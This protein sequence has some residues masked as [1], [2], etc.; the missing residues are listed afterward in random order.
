MWEPARRDR[1]N[2]HAEFASAAA[3]I[4][5]PSPLPHARLGGRGGRLSGI[6]R[7]GWILNP[8]WDLVWFVGLPFVALGIAFGFQHW[9]PYVAVASINLWIT[10]PHHYATWVRT[11]GM[12]EEWERFKDRLIVGPIVIIAMAATGYVWAPITLLL[13]ITAWDHQHSIMQQHGFGRIYD[14]KAGTGLPG[15]RRFDLALHWILYSTMLLN[16]PM[17]RHLWI[18]E[19]HKMRV[20]LSVAFVDFVT[21]AS[22]LVLGGFLIAYAWHVAQTIRSGRAV[23]PVKYVY[24]FSSYFLWYVAAWHTNSVLLFAV[25]HRIMH[26]V[27]YMVLVSAFLG[28]KAADRAARPGFWSRVSGKGRLKWFLLCG[29]AYAV[30]VQLLIQ[31]PLDEFAFGVVNFAPYQAIP[32]F[33]LPALDATAGYELFAYTIVASYGMI[34]YYVDSF[35]WKVQDKKVQ[36][37]L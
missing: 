10:I 13:L 37:G 30:V 29:G 17:F 6:F 22:W 20:P 2:H 25:A 33:N 31:R 21:M 28:R 23:N 27:Q 26:G 12:P 16:A 15:T 11:Y 24:L 19:L 8:T 9:L 34:H 14:F 7:A 1:R 18:R 3:D 5:A 35:I 32:A 4:V 36:G